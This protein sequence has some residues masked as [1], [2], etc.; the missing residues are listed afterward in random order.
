MSRFLA[1]ALLITICAGI[2]G[3]AFDTFAENRACSEAF[4]GNSFEKDLA[5][6]P[7]QL[8]NSKA[9]AL[10]SRYWSDLAVVNFAREIAAT[11]SVYMVRGSIGELKAV[12]SVTRSTTETRLKFETIQVSET[13]WGEKSKRVGLD[14]AKLVTSVMRFTIE[15]KKQNPDR[16]VVLIGDDLANEALVDMLLGFGFLPDSPGKKAR[17]LDQNYEMSF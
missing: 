8:L 7:S 11:D 15:E 16:K 4:R 12:F 1:V 10:I 17:R 6:L 9:G 14:F 2:T 3:Y 13:P 5:V